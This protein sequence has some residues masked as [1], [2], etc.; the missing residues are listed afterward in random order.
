MIGEKVYFDFKSCSLLI[1][2][3]FIIT[4]SSFSNICNCKK[5]I[6]AFINKFGSFHH[7]LKILSNNHNHNRLGS[8]Y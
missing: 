8:L 2:F 4:N 3:R 1:T 7:Q 5:K 6:L